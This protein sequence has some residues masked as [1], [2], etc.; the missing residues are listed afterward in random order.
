MPIKNSSGQIIGVIQLINKF[1]DLPFTKNDENFVEAFAIFCGMGIHNTHMYER[2]IVAIAKQ[3]VTLEVLSYHATASL[4]DAQ[5]LRVVSED[6]CWALEEH[7]DLLRAMSMTVCDLAAITKPWEVEKRVAELVSSEF[8]EQ[9]DIEREKL[10]ITP[11]SFAML[12]DKLEPL[13][14][15]VRQ[16]RIKW[17]EIAA[18]N[19]LM[20]E[21]EMNKER[22]NNDNLSKPSSPEQNHN[23]S[24]NENSCSTLTD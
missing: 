14:E 3:N 7:R 4:E 11:I 16:N 20:P 5:R 24:P 23:S 6:P 15:G 9:G 18:A 12:S 21:T 22:D 10:K 2:A 17:L 19:C 8:F 1:N 13:V